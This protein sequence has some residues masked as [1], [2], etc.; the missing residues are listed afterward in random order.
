MDAADALSTEVRIRPYDLP[1]AIMLKPDASPGRCVTFVPTDTIVVI[2]KGSDPAQ[3]VDLEAVLADA[4]PVMRRASGGCAVVI[5]PDM[6]AASFAVYGQ[7]QQ[8]S[9]DYFRDF[10]ELIIA[11]LRDS[12]V[13]DLTHAGTS[14]I[15]RQG[16]KIAGT[17][18]YRNRDVVF[19]HAILNLRGNPGIMERYLKRPPRMPEYRADRTHTEFVTSLA[20]EGHAVDVAAL[21]RAIHR[22]FAAYLQ[23]R[24]VNAA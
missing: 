7:A 14:D 24:A 20:A 5:S 10:N 23:K 2:G 18:I 4:V 22:E 6:L 8:K 11:A 19:Y 15:A 13:C 1:D 3:E 21:G 12:G 9:G 16:R 17:A